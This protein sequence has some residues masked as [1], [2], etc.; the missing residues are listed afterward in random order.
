LIVHRADWVLPIAARPIRD[1][2]VAVDSGRITGLGGGP[3]PDHL[4]AFERAA[5]SR[6]GVIL[7]GLVNAHLHFELSWMRGRVPPAASMPSWASQLMI[8]RRQHASEPEAP[9]RSAVEE[10]RSCGTVLVGDVTNTLASYGALRESPLAGVVFFEQLGF[11]TDD[12]AARA[13]DA[14]AALRRLPPSD[15]IRACVAPHAPYSVSPEFL[16]AIGRLDANVVTIHLGESKQEIQF[17]RD[18]TGAWREILESLG[19]W[20][21]RWTPPACGPVE[22][23]ARVGLL[24][25]R[26]LA[27]HGVQ[28]SD[29]ELSR[30][31]AA[32]ATIVTCPRSNMWTGAGAAPVDRFYRSGV[33]VAV[34]TDSLASVDDLNVFN[35]LA[36]MRAAAPDVKA[37][38]LLESATRS[39]A[40]ALGF[41]ADLGTIEPGKRAALI[42]VALRPGVEDVEEYLVRGIEPADIEWLSEGS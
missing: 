30:L 3:C 9:I 10:A 22:Y 20:E 40:D 6:L 31:A 1:G 39:G 34:G 19:V 38:R 7:P 42:S 12:A 13:A 36:A 5:S 35:E 11:R 15:R 23:L 32:G 37:S 2:W 16:R 27:V 8:L 25:A 17:L 4:R 26:L 18:G 24:D 21:D 14:A 28:L 33:R 29:E 41:G